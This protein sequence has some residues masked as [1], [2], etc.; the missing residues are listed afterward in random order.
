MHSSVCY[1]SR[2]W[3]DSA[4][5][6]EGL[7]ETDRRIVQVVESESGS[8]P[9]EFSEKE[10]RFAA[11]RLVLLQWGL[12]AFFLFLISGFWRLQILDP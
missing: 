10:T 4:G 12:V 8:P 9:M 7:A 1:S 2:Y 6:R 3:I 11:H 5:L